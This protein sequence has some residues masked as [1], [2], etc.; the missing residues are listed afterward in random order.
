MTSIPELLPA[1]TAMGHTITI[2]TKK[3][4]AKENVAR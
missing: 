2:N 4:D 3:A 1:D